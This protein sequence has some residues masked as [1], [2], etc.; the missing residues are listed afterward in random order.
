LSL[1]FKRRKMRLNGEWSLLAGNRVNELNGPKRSVRGYPTRFT[2]VETFL[3]DKMK[4]R[5]F[6][7]ILNHQNVTS[8]YMIL[9]FSATYAKIE[10]SGWWKD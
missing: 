6:L 5:T 2:D 10:K 1:I 4:K 8:K 9:Q 3:N 7:I